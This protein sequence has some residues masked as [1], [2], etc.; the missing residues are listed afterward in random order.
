MEINDIIKTI[1]KLNAKSISMR[2]Q[3]GWLYES[4]YYWNPNNDIKVT[5]VRTAPK[6]EILMML[7]EKRYYL[8]EKE[9]IV[10]DSSMGFLGPTKIYILNKTIDENYDLLYELIHPEVNIKYDSSNGEFYIDVFYNEDPNG[11]IK[12]ANKI[13]RA[14]N[15]YAIEPDKG[16]I[17]DKI[18]LYNV[19]SDSMEYNTIW[20]IDPPNTQTASVFSLTDVDSIRTFY[21]FIE[22]TNNEWETFIVDDHTINGLINTE[23]NIFYNPSGIH[24]I[25]YYDKNKNI[26]C[27]TDCDVDYI[28][29]LM[30]RGDSLLIDKDLISIRKYGLSHYRFDKS[31]L[32]LT[33]GEIRYV[34]LDD[35]SINFLLSTMMYV[36]KLL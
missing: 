30:G 18:N 9:I 29:S 16:W 6:T 31:N 13:T 22:E 1:I 14:F 12:L 15:K 4:I 5:L 33:N 17:V 21:K 7:K 25:E 24:T 32:T 28:S 2:N 20:F 26:L 3:I 8:I 36:Y 11:Y 27:L 34:H 19:L 10:E 23:K 35:S